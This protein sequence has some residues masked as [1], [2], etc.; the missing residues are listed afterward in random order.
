MKKYIVLIDCIVFPF[1]IL[2]KDSVLW[3]WIITTLLAGF[4][5]V[6]TDLLLGKP[7]SEVIN[8]GI[9][10]IFSITLLI[11]VIS[12]S[13]IYLCSEDK[14]LEAEVKF[15]YNSEKKLL[16]IINKY[17]I[18]K[19][20]AL[21]LFFDI[22]V[23]LVSILL[24]AGTYKSNVWIQCMIGVVSLYITFY[25]FCLNRVSQYPQN[26]NEYIQNE[27]KGI[28]TLEAKEQKASSFT[29]D[30]GNEVTL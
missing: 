30:N 21:I 18:T 19:Y 6:F 15:K 22:M 27:N 29:N 2:T 8:Q 17:S 4:F 11:P 14:K 7:V 26:Y 25:Y 28:E 10:Y 3:L 5:T 20:L 23:M 1:K 13:I 9:I 16:P 12:D 24:Y